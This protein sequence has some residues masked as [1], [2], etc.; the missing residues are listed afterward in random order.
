MARLVLP[1]VVGIG[2]ERA[3]QE[4]LQWVALIALACLLAVLA[5]WQGPGRRF[6]RRWWFG[7]ALNAWLFLLGLLLAH[8]HDERRQP[9][10]LPSDTGKETLVLGKVA[11]LEPAAGKLRLRVS[12]HAVAG[13]TG[14]LQP[15]SG[16]V[17]AYLDITAASRELQPGDVLL[18]H[19]GLRPAPGP[20]NPNAFDYRRYLHYRNVHCQAFVDEG[21]WKLLEHRP[22]LANRARKLRRACLQVLRRHLPTGNEYAVASALIL[23]YKAEL[24]DET[25]NAYAH[26]GAMHVLAVSGLHVGIIQLLLSF[27]LGLVRLPWR[28]WPWM[29]LALLLAGIWGFAL[30]TGASPSVLRAATLF[31]FLSAGQA[32][33][34]HTNIYNTLAASAFLL[35]CIDPYLLFNVGFQLSYLAVLAIVYFQPLFYRQWYIE[36]RAGDYLWKLFAVSLAAQLGTLPL[37]LYYFHQF[38]LY[39]WLS[40]LVVVPAAAI[41]LSSGLALFA[42][43]LVPVL[44]MA[45][46]KLLYGATWMVNAL[47]FLIRE[48]PGGLLE[49]F[50]I[51][52]E[53][54]LL[55]YLCI[56]CIILAR[57]TRNFKWASGALAFLLAVAAI[58]AGRAVEVCHQRALVVYHI[59]RSTA[60]E[61]FEGRS[62]RLLCSASLPDKQ[63]EYAALNHRW[64][65]RA[66]LDA[67][68]A[69]SGS[70]QGQGW[71]Y[72]QGALQ[73]GPHRLLVVRDRTILHAKARLSIDVALLCDGVDM[74][75]AELW[76][77]MNFKLLLIDGSNPPWKARK[78]KEEARA[79]GVPCHYTGED[80]AWVG[81]WGGEE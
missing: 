13:P 15:A 60:I 71:W 1:L 4:W 72:R 22:G 53:T 29:R 47:V 26:T 52:W 27:L 7:L 79:L 78:W 30:L 33:K 49:G 32:L 3:G 34:R 24:P 69:L 14:E 46:G 74:K 12:V 56:L 2:V 80:G 50:W 38:P 65:R 55:L 39:F 76:E 67:R 28:Y 21:G 18:L 54:A 20:L 58:N 10:Y 63:L 59:P 40:G 61:V 57:E 11:G 23:G 75:V 45:A 6:S 17:L 68:R 70:Q 62:A 77:Q 37:S 36:N 81:E 25:R 16:N 42:L 48:I 43:H 73:Y 35:L 66:T 64:Y 41:I 9:G 31:S 8:F 5:W 19:A 51:G 44:G